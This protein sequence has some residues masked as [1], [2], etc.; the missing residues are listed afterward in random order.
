MRH[1][2]K[3][4]NLSRTTKHRKALL[5]NLANALIQ[6]KRIFT[7]LAKAKALRTFVEPILTKA[8]TDSQHHR[9]LVYA[10]LQN[11]ESVKTL[12]RE[13]SEK[14]ANRNGGYTRIIK[15]GNRLGD[16]AEMAMIELVDFNEIYTGKPEKTEKKKATRRSRKKSSGTPKAENNSGTSESAAKT[17]TEE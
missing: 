7:T 10:Y 11:K 9:R 16:A 6:H 1:G 17:K 14:I 3:I 12:F 5:R 2:D 8:K 15:V 13:V 4:N